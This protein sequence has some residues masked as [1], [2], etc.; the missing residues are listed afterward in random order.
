MR[1]GPSSE[2]VT[3]DYTTT[4][5]TAFADEDY[6]TTSGTLSFAV[7]VT[8]RT[9]VVPILNDTIHESDEMFSVD[10]SNPS[11]SAQLGPQ[12]TANVLIRDNDDGGAIF[13]SVENFNAR[14]S[15]PSALIT[16]LRIGGRASDVTVDF[17]VSNGTALEDSDYVTTNGTLTF[18]AGVM[19]LTFA[20]PLLEDVLDE[21]NET[22]LL[23]LSNPTGGATLGAR[24]EATATI[25]DNDVAGSLR[26]SAATYSASETGTVAMI[27]VRR[28]GGRAGG[29]S[30]EYA[31]TNEVDY[32]TSAGS[33][34]FD[35][36]ETTKTFTV[37]ILDD[38]LPDGNKAVRLSLAN[39]SGGA[40]LIAPTNAILNIMDDELS[41][42][43]GSLEYSVHEGSRSVSITVI[44]SG[45]TAPAFTVHYATS[46]D[47][48]TAGSDYTTKSGILTFG[49]GVV[50]QTV[51]VSLRSDVAVEGDESFTVTLDSPTGGAELG[52]RNMTTVTI[53][54]ND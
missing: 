38:T 15:A 44:R 34:M 40:R 42:Q 28:S 41:V 4:D 48:A 16:V 21:P 11:G 31:A 54:D 22:I 36:N 6:A 43:F 1:T 26:F 14:E 33:V 37:P 25:L 29:V 19:R 9:I 35:A 32:T 45:P 53:V 12:D 5:D 20:I 30:V 47:T 3:V 8:S 39:V 2:V 17:A 13:F 23:S 51:T 10:L 27:T 46:D 7:G 49:R 18:G 50:K 24:S 52:P